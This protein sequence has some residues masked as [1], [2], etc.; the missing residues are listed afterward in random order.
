MKSD[1]IRQAFLEFFKEK[2]HKIIPSA[3]LIP[4]NDPTVLFTTAGMHPL[5]PYLMGETHPEGTRLVN[6]QK[7]L[8][9][10]DIDE[11]GD[12]SHLTFFEMLGN[13]S[14]GDYFKREAIQWSFE[15][16]T[17]KKW[18]GLE[19]ERLAVT[20]FAGDSEAPRDTESAEI[21]RSLGI[22]EHRISFLPKEKNWWIAGQTGP[23][24]PDTEMHYWIDDSAPAPEK[25][26][27][28][29]PRWVEIWNDVFMQFDR[30][31]DGRL[32]PLPRPNVDTGMGFERITAVLQKK[33]NIYE[34]DLFVPIIEKIRSLAKNSDERRER[35]IADHLRAATFLISDGVIP[36]NKDRGYILRRLIRR[37]VTFGKQLGI[38]DEFSTEIAA[39][40]INRY[41]FA[42]HALERHENR[43]L[44]ELNKEETKYRET[45]KSGL[46]KIEKT[47][48]SKANIEDKDS[49]DKISDSLFD[50]YQSD[51]M[52][53]EVSLEAMGYKDLPKDKL[54]ALKEKFD[55]KVNHHQELSR[56]ASAGQFKGGLASNSEKIT[57]YHTATHLMNAALRKV[58]G[59]HVYQK[60]SNIT[61]ERTRFDF[62]HDRKLTDEEKQRVEA[63][64][65]EW[66]GRDLEVTKEIM[67]EQQA[68]DKGAIGVFGEKYPE[69]VSVYTVQD[70]ASGEVVSREF[71]GGPHVERTGSIGKFRIA[72]EEAV[73]A[74]IRR[75]KAVIE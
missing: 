42:Y 39:V 24:G 71:C 61:E 70:P 4:E 26:D 11:V 34:T 57:R 53:F 44:E 56:T 41:K 22:P 38:E 66:I 37:A 35:I 18:L 54:D 69:N 74:G 49:L 65:N 36:S 58:L 16:L 3:S 14:L 32:S 55:G 8:R 40:V 60:G 68:R 43:I 67:T 50:L 23:C 46:K 51:G 9:T 21:W 59:D 31:A 7:C 45:L 64:V 12:I 47:L 73:A 28:D 52:P 10:D 1:E 30:Q 63:L 27:P 33:A 72:K 62:T 19:I 5:I 20:C 48:L 75:I 6:F 29:E 25:Y 17:S 15:F 2:G 13:W